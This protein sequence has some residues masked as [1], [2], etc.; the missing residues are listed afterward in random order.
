MIYKALYHFHSYWAY[1]VL[2]IVVLA[3]LNALVGLF[4][5]RPF[6]ARDF[7]IS[8]FG[9]IV[10]HLQ[11][12]IG[13]ILFFVSPRVQWFNDQVD[14]AQIM[15]DSTLRLYNV[16]HPLM[17]IVSVALITIGYSRHKKK[18]TS[19]AKFKQL[20]IFYVLATIALLSMIPWQ[21]WF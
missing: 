3:T 1:L 8:L 2:L 13:L 20:S 10:T 21:N 6:A 14:V 15:G 12:L 17:M 11:L 9:I 18:L 7:R 4:G 16:E 19:G 5:K